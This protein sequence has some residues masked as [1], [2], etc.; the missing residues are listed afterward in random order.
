MKAEN[1][2]AGTSRGPDPAVTHLCPGEARGSSALLR[3][4]LSRRK[5]KKGDKEHLLIAGSTFGHLSA[6]SGSGGLTQS[7]VLM[8]LERK[9]LAAGWALVSEQDRRGPQTP[10]GGREN[11]AERNNRKPNFHLMSA[12]QMLG[13]LQGGTETSTHLRLGGAGAVAGGLL[14][15][16]ISAEGGV[17]QIWSKQMRQRKNTPGSLCA[18]PSMRPLIPCSMMLA[19]DW[20]PGGLRSDPA[21]TGAFS[22]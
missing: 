16:L 10:A 5:V 3:D 7:P 13:N 11:T 18:P 22:A 4:D 19:P 9:S 12:E 21:V 2:S 15:G 17:F 8:L 20:L 14:V 6:G 1:R